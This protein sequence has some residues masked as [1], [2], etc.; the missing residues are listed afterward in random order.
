[1]G[2]LGEAIAR[3]L[4]LDAPPFIVGAGRT[5]A[6]VHALAQVISLDLARSSVDEAGIESLVRSLNHQLRGRVVVREARI[7]P[8]FHARFDATWR[9][10]RYL[11]TTGPAL[12]PTD[13]L[14]WAVE[15]TLDVGAMNDAS[16]RLVGVHDFRAF[17]KRA[18]DKAAGEP[19]VRHVYEARWD[20]QPDELALGVTG[21]FLVFWIRA[22]AFCHNQVR[23]LVGALVAV[24]RGA[25]SPAQFEDRLTSGR[26]ERLPAPAP[27]S[28]LALAAVGYDDA[29]GG[30]SGRAGAWRSV[31]SPV[32]TTAN[33]G[34][35][36]AELDPSIRPQD[37]LFGYVNQRWFDATPIPEDRASYGTFWLLAEAAER[38]VREIVEAAREADSGTDARRLGDLYASFLDEERIESLGAAPI[39][40]RLAQVAAV[41]SIPSFVALV[42]SLEREGL[43]GFYQLF[44]D[45]DPGDPERYLVFLE[46]GGLSL[47]DESYYREDHFADVRSAFV[48]HVARTLELAGL[49]DAAARAERVMALESELAGGHWD[50]VASRD[51]SATYNLRTL[52]AVLAQAEVLGD[53]FNA[54]GRGALGE[55]V[56]RQP[57]FT[58]NLVALL[59]EAHLAAWRDWLSWQVVRGASAYLSSPFVEAHFDFYGRTL[60]GAP[61]L[62]A[63]WK[64]AV[65]LVE[66]AMGEAV[67]RLYVEAHFAP[68]AKARMDELVANLVAAYRASIETLSWMGE[69][70]RARALEKLAAFTPKIG[71]PPRWRDYSALSVDATDL[72][73]NVRA[74]AAFEFDRQLAKIGQPVDRDEW[75]MTPQTVNA[76]YNPGMN[77]IVF[78]AAILQPPF[79][80]AD[81]DD[82]ANY[83]AI[84]AVI[85]HEIGH[86]FD[87]QGSKF[88][89]SGRLADWWEA[90]DRTAFEA[91]TKVLIDQYDALVPRTVPSQHVNG[92]L[93]IGE[94]IGD[95]GGLGIA[96]RAYQIARGD[97]P[98]PVIDGLTGA[99]RFLLA[100]A[101]SWRHI[102]RPAEAERLLAIDPHSPPEFR[103]N[104]VV[105]NLDVFYEAFGVVEGDALWLAASERVTIW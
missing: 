2:H 12:G 14:A 3:S 102:A 86:G 98:D 59:D 62:R 19:L 37:D 53:W 26:A 61:E 92:G 10:Y 91:K 25:L 82:A 24:G 75:F 87:D 83:G 88:D 72:M 7:I 34:I 55:L 20:T 4:R 69:A 93:T 23:R 5:D 11:V 52:D 38:H 30:P 39:A 51:M 68:S 96:W 70:T 71:Y 95:L 97:G 18:P 77:E 94:N 15:G 101:L 21:E 100:W 40:A 81:R 90:A 57:S 9:G 50:A 104:Q 66:G 8:E 54:V 67:G 73:A 22:N 76:Y 31:G 48:A 44:V 65:A 78:P 84:G 27:A 42:G 60:T 47:P 6:G 45:N 80:D 105:R 79:F 17:C 99:Q 36:P 33:A 28:G 43:A 103:C 89:G 13:A 64:R 74:A 16:S 32:M 85:G 1:M 49:D 58:T 29:H 63:R 41:R 46:Q 56:L 35:D